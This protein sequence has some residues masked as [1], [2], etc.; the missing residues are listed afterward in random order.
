MEARAHEV[1][2]RENEHAGAAAKQIL[3][4]S[5][6]AGGDDNVNEKVWE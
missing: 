3:K 6:A 5:A 4:L 2:Q 1:E